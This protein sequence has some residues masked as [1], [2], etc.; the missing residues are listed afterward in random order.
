MEK[1]FSLNFFSLIGSCVWSVF[2]AQEKNPEREDGRI[3]AYSC[4]S[5]QLLPTEQKEKGKGEDIHYIIF[6]LLDKQ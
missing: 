2:D 4:F 1:Y 5:T 3:R 6:P